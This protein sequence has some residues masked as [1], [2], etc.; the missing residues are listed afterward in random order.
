MRPSRTAIV[1]LALGLYSALLSAVSLYCL[2]SD[3]PLS[4]WLY[5]WLDV[6]D[7]FFTIPV[8]GLLSVMLALIQL[9]RSRADRKYS[10][11][12]LAF[13]LLGLAIFWMMFDAL[14]GAASLLDKL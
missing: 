10:L 4:Q 9:V 5:R 3:S 2:M 12:A 6:E 11:S 13:N 7:L 1:A 8:A 14:S